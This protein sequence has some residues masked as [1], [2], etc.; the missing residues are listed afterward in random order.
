MIPDLKFDDRA[1]RSALKRFE[2]NSKRSREAVLKDQ[3]RLFVRDVILVT[4][5]NKNF[6]LNRKGGEAAVS[7]DIRKILRQ[8]KAKDA[9][10]DP[11]DIHARF[12]DRHTGR[13]NKRNLKTK[14]RVANLA[15]YIKKELE[16]V[17][18]LASG[19]NAAAAKLGARVPEWISRHGTGRGAIKITV[20][21]AEVR[22][23]ITNA[24][25]FASGVDGLI[26]RVQAALD[27]RTGAMNRQVDHFQKRAAKEA[28]F[29]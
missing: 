15:V 14:Y 21:L 18:I 27:K 5:P 12:R 26:R 13:V 17:G 8:S 22:I 24:V 25:K 9:V 10:S 29:K 7:N 16:K 4:P 11:S 1:F 19:W 20:S 23:T 28:G 2:A 3:A 6:K